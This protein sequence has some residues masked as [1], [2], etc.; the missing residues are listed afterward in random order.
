L[1]GHPKVLKQTILQG[2]FFIRPQPI[3]D[4]IGQQLLAQASNP[5]GFK[6]IPLEEAKFEVGTRLVKTYTEGIPVPQHREWSDPFHRNLCPLLDR[7]RAAWQPLHRG[8]CSAMTMRNNRLNIGTYLC[9][10]Q[11]NKSITYRHTSRGASSR[12]FPLLRTRLHFV[13][14]RYLR[15][16]RLL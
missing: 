4:A 5:S 10:Y 9:P 12:T 15:S 11:D 16:K 1:Y 13:D 2:P 7:Q 14:V 8:V 6:K 3:D